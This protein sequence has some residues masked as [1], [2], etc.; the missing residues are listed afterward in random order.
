MNPVNSAE[1]VY[2]NSLFAVLIFSSVHWAAT[3]VHSASHFAGAFSCLPSFIF[4]S[5]LWWSIYLYFI[6]VQLCQYWC[7]PI[8]Y[9]VMVIL[10]ANLFYFY[11][12]LLISQLMTDVSSFIVKIPQW[13]VLFFFKHRTS[14]CYQWKPD[15]NNYSFHFPETVT[16]CHFLFLLHFSLIFISLK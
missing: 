9:S 3:S 8:S 12:L 16:V 5:N 15:H 4:T 2:Q 1:R 6:Q 10:T 7:Y 11:F 13:A 14:I